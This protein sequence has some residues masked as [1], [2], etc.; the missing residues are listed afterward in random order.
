MRV[1]CRRRN[2]RR[3]M[4][5]CRNSRRCNCPRLYPWHVCDRASQAA[6]SEEA[7]RAARAGLPIR[8]G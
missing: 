6:A 4:E 1:R 3:V 5:P 7:G 2:V 8:R